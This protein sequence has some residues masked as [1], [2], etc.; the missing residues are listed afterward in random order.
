M[1]NGPNP[2]AL[3]L[4][5]MLNPKYFSMANLDL[6]NLGMT[7]ILIWQTKKEERIIEQFNFQEKKK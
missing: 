5:V 7:N 4:I 1:P 3:Y 6:K 2:R